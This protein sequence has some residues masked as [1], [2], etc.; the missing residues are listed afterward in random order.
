MKNKRNFS[1]NPFCFIIR[2]RSYNFLHSLRVSPVERMSSDPLLFCLF[3]I[4][5]FP[6][7]LVLGNLFIFVRLAFQVGIL[8]L[9][10]WRGVM[11]QGSNGGHRFSVYFVIFARYRLETAI[12]IVAFTIKIPNLLLIFVLFRLRVHI[13]YPHMNFFTGWLGMG[14]NFYHLQGCPFLKML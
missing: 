13:L 8:V 3:K 11:I 6:F 14:H 9:W 1:S 12:F 5:F 2:P 4:P 7:C 10:G